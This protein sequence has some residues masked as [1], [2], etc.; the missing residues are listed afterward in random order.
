VHDV[1]YDLFGTVAQNASRSRAIWQS[2][3][4]RSFPCR[5]AFAIAPGERRYH[6]LAIPILNRSGTVQL[7]HILS[8]NRT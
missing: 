5:Q 1:T 8:E 7:Q 4:S 2:G 3:A 6:Q